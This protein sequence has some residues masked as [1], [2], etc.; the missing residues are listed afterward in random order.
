[1]KSLRKWL[2]RWW[3]CRTKRCT[4]YKHYLAYGPADLTHEGFHSAEEN[5]A[6][7]Q[8]RQLAWMREH[9]NDDATQPEELIN[10][11]EFWE[12]KVRA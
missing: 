7:W 1:M 4:Y 11:C 2:R 8:A 9:E 5:C 10:Q 3:E 12:K 6:I